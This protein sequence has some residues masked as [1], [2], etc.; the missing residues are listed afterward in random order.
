MKIK[1]LIGV[2]MIICCSHS[3]YSQTQ[4]DNIKHNKYTGTPIYLSAYV[5]A[6]YT[7][8]MFSAKK[9]AVIQSTGPRSG[10]SFGG[11]L[12]IRFKQPN[13]RHSAV[14]SLLGA[15]VG[16]SYTASGFK[17][18]DSDT[19]VKLSDISFPIYFQIYPISSLLIEAG[20]EF[21][22]NANIKPDIAYIDGAGNIGFV[23]SDHAANDI[24]IGIGL[25][26]YK[27]YI[28]FRIRYLIGTSDFASNLPLKG[29]QLKL[30]MFVRFGINRSKSST[31][32]K[33]NL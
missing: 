1:Y 29:N 12:N 9:N 22:V 24:K 21:S 26:Y 5:E 11:G 7:L 15:Q 6:D 28:G 14:N 23:M 10:V 30:G 32:V 18:K 27:N 2:I 17:I 20:P 4:F 19:K 33:I 16:I 31:S 8:S 25:G 13:S 3:A